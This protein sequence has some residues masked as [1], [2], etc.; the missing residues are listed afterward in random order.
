MTSFSTSPFVNLIA[1]LVMVV[2]SYHLLALGD[3]Q[4]LLFSEKY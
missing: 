3:F 2:L 1:F 4:N